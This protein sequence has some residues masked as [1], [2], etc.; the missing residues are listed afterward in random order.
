MKKKQL[1]ALSL[2]GF[3]AMLTLAG[4]TNDVVPS[5]SSQSV[6]TH[7]AGT[8]WEHDDKSHWHVCTSCGEKFD[9][10]DHSYEDSV[11]AATKDTM[12]YTLHTC[13]CGYSYKDTFTELNYSITFNGGDKAFTYDIAKEAKALDRVYF[14][15]SVISGYQAYDVTATYKET[16][17]YVD[18]EDGEEKEKTVVK[19]VP[20]SGSYEFGLY[21]FMPNADVTVTV[22]T[23][24]IGDSYYKV[25]A[26]DDDI[27][28]D[29][30]NE[31]ATD[32]KV[33]DFIAG[34]IVD[35][36]ITKGTTLYAHAGDTVSVLTN[37][38][39]IADNVKYFCDGEELE[40]GTYKYTVGKGAD[41]VTHVYDVVEFTMPLHSVT[42]T[43]TAD[44]RE[45]EIGVDAP[46]YVTTRLYKL[47]EDGKKVDVTSTKGGNTVYLQTEFDKN[48]NNGNYKINNVKAVYKTRNG[49]EELKE[50][51]ETSSSMFETTSGSGIYSYKVTTST[52]YYGDITFK[53]TVDEAKF[54]KAAWAGSYGGV[55]ILHS[56]G[57]YG[58]GTYVYGYSTN[59][60]ADIFGLIARG[61]T[62][63]YVLDETTENG[64][65]KL[66]IASSSTGTTAT[67]HV[68]YDN[69]LMVMNDNTSYEITAKGDFYIVVKDKTGSNLDV[70]FSEDGTAGANGFVLITVKDKTSGDELGNVLRAGT[71]IYL[72]VTVEYAD[73]STSVNASSSFVVKK[74]GKTL[75]TYKA[76]EKVTESASA[77]E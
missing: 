58:R 60:T 42:L 46:E 16:V 28:V 19:E 76:G 39:A 51:S 23:R 30:E 70:T 45:Y 18:E 21:F 26:N 25:S 59:A 10:A 3:G 34:Y 27:V 35:D 54:A 24:N 77:A 14:T 12:G 57:Y 69:G 2:I 53:V 66:G 55:E 75:A 41:A 50:Y 44:E 5:S 40:A 62:K 52:D 68:Y 29:V 74:D 11:V 1:F 36:V 22:S 38:V 47:D 56:T 15:M 67:S 6:H 72:N 13:K 4:C 32:K 48:H 73:G 17:T 65:T 64:S 43:V 33:S 8:T 7:V 63:M 31:N 20:V 71:D 9:L 49:Y 61:S 37:Y